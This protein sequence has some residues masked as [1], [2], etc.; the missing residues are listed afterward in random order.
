METWLAAIAYGRFCGDQDKVCLKPEY[1]EEM[2]FRAE[3]E[4]EH[5]KFLA[6]RDVE[7][8]W[9]W[10]TPAGQIRA[11]RRAALIASG[12]ELKPGLRALEIGC[13][14]GLFTQMFCQTGASI[15]AVDISGDLLEKAKE[16]NLPAANVT[17]IEKRFE[18]R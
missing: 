4:I 1:R 8:I 11:R 3:H 15:V 12:A 2:S 9:G 7:S 6:M 10:G 5:G 13:G 14:T 16:R 18:L 17:F